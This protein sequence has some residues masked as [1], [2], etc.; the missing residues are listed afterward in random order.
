M[1]QCGGQ[2][3]AG[4][5]G[6]SMRALIFVKHPQGGIK[7][8]CRYMYAN[9]VMSDL[10]IEFM[11]PAA[12]GEAYF[13]EYLGAD[14]RFVKTGD[15]GAS[16]VWSLCKSLL[17]NR[18]DLVHSHGFT[19]GIL[20]AI[21]TRIFGV[22]HIVTSHD[23]FQDSQFS[24]LRG[25][26]K[27]KLVGLAL[28]LANRINPVGDDARENLVTYYPSLDKGKKVVAIR[29][30]VDTAA[31][32]SEG[33]RDVKAE[34]AL[35]E[36]ELLL[37]YF[38]R[39]MAQKGFGLLVNLVDEWNREQRYPTLRV[40]CFGWGGY[41]REEQESLKQRGLWQYFRFFDATDSMVEAL[42][43]VDVV[44]MPSRWEACP[45]LAMEALTAGVPLIA[46]NCIGNREVT[47]DTPAW[48]FESESVTDFKRVLG[49]LVESREQAE[50][51]ADRFRSVAAERFD[52]GAAARSLHV[53]FQQT[54]GRANE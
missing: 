31:F 29:N 26:I 18:P 36:G 3:E 47:K 52:V 41:I 23:I 12:D 10:Q 2:P 54:L 45:L 40:A 49:E 7:T 11:T 13:R 25:W 48:V 43:G 4:V 30:G 16:M 14:I 38:G 1:R 8:Y 24:G 46:S 17:G 33:R 42:R 44:A 15:S 27:R 50:A 32:L 20:A 53:L 9:P 21:P 37:G 28:S 5:R 35:E 51:S 34:M 6:R 22:K 19:A 39:F